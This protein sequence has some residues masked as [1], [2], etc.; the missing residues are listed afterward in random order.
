[1][2][3]WQ[4]LG[5]GLV[6]LLFLWTNLSAQQDLSEYRSPDKAISTKIVKS[7]VTALTARAYLGV[8]AGLDGNGWLVV[9][10][11][12]AE[13]PAARAGVR[14]GDQLLLG[15]GCDLKDEVAL[16]NL[17]QTKSPGEA[18]ALV[19]ARQGKRLDL[20]AGL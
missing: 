5:L 2:R 11:V 9:K 10:K 19:L 1:M 3:P 18:L 16:E 7:Q 4:R 12:A 14:A 15:D 8:Q 6:G 17:L 20:T 13:S